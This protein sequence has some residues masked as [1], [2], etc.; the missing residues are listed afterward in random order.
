MTDKEIDDLTRELG[1]SYL[2]L[3]E[4]V[5]SNMDGYI[6]DE[7]LDALID[8]LAGNPLD[9]YEYIARIMED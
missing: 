9:L 7:D 3:R 4:F 1:S 6:S 2:D 8:E 5:L